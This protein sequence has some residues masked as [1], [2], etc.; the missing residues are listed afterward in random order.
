MH[1]YVN[2][3]TVIYGSG[4]K[5]RKAGEILYLLVIM[6]EKV[7]W[8]CNYAGVEQEVTPVLTELPKT[9][10]VRLFR[11]D[12]CRAQFI[13]PTLLYYVSNLLS[14]HELETVLV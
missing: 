10:A 1:T 5:A 4:E 6:G 11:R 14:S 12:F 9:T 7:D 2:T 13:F 8:Y 3:E